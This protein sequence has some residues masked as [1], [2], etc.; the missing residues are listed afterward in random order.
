M[1]K[2]DL[3]D[4]LDL[5]VLEVRH[6]PLF[7]DLIVE[8]RAYL[9]ES[10]DFP[11]RFQTLE[12]V[13]SYIKRAL[14]RYAEDGLPMTGLWLDEQFIGSVLFFPVDWHIRSTEMGYWLAQRASGRG[15]MTRAARA[16]VG[17]AFDTVNL[18]RVELKVDVSNARSTALAVRLG[19]KL[20][21]VA[22]QGAI[23]AGKRADLATY[24]MLASEW[25]SLNRTEDV[26]QAR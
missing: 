21:G 5:R 15:L 4:G 16:M 13:Q 1:F 9:A 23:H 10:L 11:H 7:F 14:T 25:T 20:E 6:A 18:N 26:S 24:S 3:G 17:F 12:D 22:R 19:F 2:Y 8:N